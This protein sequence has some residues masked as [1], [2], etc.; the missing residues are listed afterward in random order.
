M[1]YM[2][3]QIRIPRECLIDCVTYISEPDHARKLKFSSNVHLTSINRFDQ[4]CLA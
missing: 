2:I 3:L 4:Y 1:L